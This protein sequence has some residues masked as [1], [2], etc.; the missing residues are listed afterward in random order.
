MH[1]VKTHCFASKVDFHQRI[2]QVLPVAVKPKNLPHPIHE[3]IVHCGQKGGSD[4]LISTLK[5][6]EIKYIHTLGLTLWQVFSSE[7]PQGEGGSSQRETSRP[8]QVSFYVLFLR[9]T[10]TSISLENTYKHTQSHLY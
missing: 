6:D 7:N 1:Q 3:G 2:H 10:L 9:H 4:L 8:Q 5:A